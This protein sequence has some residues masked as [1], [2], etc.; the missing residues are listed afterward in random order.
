MSTQAIEAVPL[1]PSPVDLVETFDRILAQRES[2]EAVLRDAFDK[3]AKRVYLVG[4]GG[5][6]LANFNAA[7]LLEKHLA[8]VTVH[9]ITSGEFLAREPLGVNAD[10]IVIA[11]SHTGGTKETVAS[12]EFAKKRGATVLAYC[13]N[14]DTALGAA[15][16]NFWS[17]DSKTTT[18]DA[19]QLFTAVFA[20]AVLKTAGADLDFEAIERNYAKLGPAI[21]QIHEKVDAEYGELA[22]KYHTENVTYVVGSG[23]GQAA[24]YNLSMCYLMEMQWM[25]SGFFNAAEFFHGAVEIVEDDVPVF[26]FLGEDSTRPLAERVRDFAVQRSSKVVTF[27]SKDFE[28]E[29]FD[30]EYRY[31]AAPHILFTLTGRLAA[32]YAILN[33]HD[34]STRR[35]MGKVAY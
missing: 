1:R 7:Y 9:H 6:Y 15:S 25:N 23:P 10:A 12:V 19:K 33:N 27:D 30:E 14:A 4:S 26:V 16:P 20:Y 21:K 18:G 13:S 11:G 34:L 31:L 17:Y 2:I 8:D 3:G 28:L 32:Q 29:G 5:S 24:A 22:K 35:Y